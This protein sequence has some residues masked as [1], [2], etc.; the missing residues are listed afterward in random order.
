MFLTI[1][2]FYSKDYRNKMNF[3][4]SYQM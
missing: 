2:R 4:K 3:F 1:K